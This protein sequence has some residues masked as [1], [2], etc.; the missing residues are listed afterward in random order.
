MNRERL[1]DKKWIEVIRDFLKELNS[2]TQLILVALVVFT[3]AYSFGSCGKK[4]QMDE[5]NQKYKQ[6]QEQVEKEKHRSDSLQNVVKLRA[7]SARKDSIT[8]AKQ[9]AKIDSLKTSLGKTQSSKTRLEQEIDSLKALQPDT[10]QISLKKDTLIANLRTDS[11]NMQRTISEL[12]KRDT[13]RLEEIA[14]HKQ[15]VLTQTFRADNLQAKLNLLPKP[16]ADPDRW[17]FGLVKKPDRVI[18][19]AVSFVAG[20]IGGIVLTK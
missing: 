19:G 8:A 13:T 11:T 18:V 4:T 10:T 20:V 2:T 6:Y 14:K 12:E 17:L 16:P 7:D 5:Y 1:M 15:N 9:T 3:L